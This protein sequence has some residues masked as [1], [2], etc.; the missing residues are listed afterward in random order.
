[1]SDIGSLARRYWLEALWGAFTLANLA[2]I[3]FLADWE[4][5]PFHFI[6]VSL[7][8]L[9]GVRVWS[10]RTTTVLLGAVVVATGAALIVAVVRSHEG[11]DEVT[12]VPLMAG[13]FLAMVWHAR[14]RQAATDAARR[15]ADNEHRLLERQR[16]FVRDA[17]HEL[18]TPI[19]IARGHAELL[20]AATTDP[21]A[22]GDAD[23]V[24]DELDRLSNLSERLLALA[25]AEDVDLVRTR[26][27]DARALVEETGR[28]WSVA[29]PRSWRVACAIDGT[30]PAD[31]DRLRV[32]IDALVENAV[33]ATD[34]GGVVA[35]D[36]RARG[37]RFELI[38]TDEG[39]G[40]DPERLSTLFERFA[41]ADAP[42]SRGTGGT[43]LGLPIVRAI[44]LAHGG[45]VE[46]ESA[47]GLGSTFRILLPGFVP[48]PTGSGV[49]DAGP[50]R[51][52]AARPAREVRAG[53]VGGP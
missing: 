2:V 17:S 31:P 35:V 45:S 28:R 46:A 6:W 53:P 39:M 43:G 1:V 15:M 49:S 19:T 11:F 18:R 10:V 44:A 33:N 37:D 12:E 8:L 16:D 36:G 7:T 5:I 3:V 9:Y 52:D 21:A 42:R 4:T 41:R 14:R 32:A 25:A 47:E 51:R 38:V 30:V 26:R 20:R 24:I 27:V 13:M 50:A 40:I 22:T 29:A 34:P 23:V 48:T